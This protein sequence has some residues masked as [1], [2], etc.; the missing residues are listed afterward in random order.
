MQV[1]VR[2]GIPRRTISGWRRRTEGQQQLRR[3][4]FGCG[5]THDFSALPRDSYAYL[6]GLYLGDGCISAAPRSVWR[7]R[8]TLD[9]AYPT[10]ID[11]GLTALRSVFPSN[12][13]SAQQRRKGRCVDL[14]LWSKHLPCLFPQHGPGRKHERDVSLRP[15]QHQLVEGHR[16]SL[17]RA[18]LRTTATAI[19]ASP[20]NARAPTKGG[21]PATRS[22]TAPRTSRRSSARAST[23]ASTSSSAR[24]TERKALNEAPM[25]RR[26]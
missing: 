14:S 7:L 5:M 21:R 17:V 18:L 2:T 8:I 4:A 20:S 22:A 3:S 13:A 26:R 11:E 23:P 19:A 10:V 6:L 9:A 24:S 12:S 25:R 15:W 1:S 16:K